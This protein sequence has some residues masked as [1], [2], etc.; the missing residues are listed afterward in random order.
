[1]R[2]PHCARNPG[3]LPGCGCRMGKDHTVLIVMP[4]AFHLGYMGATRRLFHFAAA[5][6]E[7]GFNTVLLAGKRVGGRVQAEIDRQFPALVLRT[8]H[9]GAYPRIVDVGPLLRR[10]WRGLWKARGAEYYAARLSFGWADVLDI[11]RVLKEFERL[12]IKPD[13]IWAVSAG[14]LEGAVAADR[15]SKVLKVPWILELRDPPRGCGLGPQREMICKEFTR[16]LQASARQVV[17]TDSYREH[18]VWKFNLAPEHIWTI[19]HCIENDPQ[20]T[21]KGGEC[22]RIAYAGSLDEGRSLSPVI[23]AYYTAVQREPSLRIS[24][25]LEIAGTGPGIYEAEKLAQRLGVEVVIHGPLPKEKA[26]ELIRRAHLL[27]VVQSEA[28][29]R[30]QV[31]GKIFD[32][33]ASGVPILGIMPQCEGADILCRS[34]LG[35]IHHP[36]DVDGIADTLIKLW[37]DWRAGV[38]SVQVNR[39]FVSQFSV[40]NLPEKLCSVLEGLV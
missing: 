8:E 29:C 17:T 14:Y 1:M 27:I 12:A 30:F 5:F 10:A 34:G 4:D 13:I 25:L 21:Y 35:F 15:L 19:H 2:L 20:V 40:K 32:Y 36:G 6:Q 33:I 7:L 38:I 28:S 22:W 37:S 23:W 9:S 3:S 26:G 31:P 18:L 24:S 39:D 11:S 16:L